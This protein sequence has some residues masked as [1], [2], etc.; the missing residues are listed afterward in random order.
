MPVQ[1]APEHNAAGIHPGSLASS[2]PSPIKIHPEPLLTTLGSSSRHSPPL[3]SPPSLSSKEA[4]APLSVAAPPP[5]R[6]RP[7]G[8]FL[9]SPT[10]SYVPGSKEYFIKIA[11]SVHRNNRRLFLPHLRPFS[12]PLSPFTPRCISIQLVAPGAP[13]GTSKLPQASLCF[14]FLSSELPSP[15]SPSSPR[16]SSLALHRPPS[17][18]SSA[19]V[20][21]L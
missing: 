8:F 18:S 3:S 10:S 5:H 2:P 12:L 20:G 6:R 21:S 13:E 11:S 14:P 17:S 4:Q 9:S 1:H 15:A 16:S 7:R 19:P